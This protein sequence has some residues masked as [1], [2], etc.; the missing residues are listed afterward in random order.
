[1]RKFCIFL[2]ISFF[3]ISC[4]YGEKITSDSF[5]DVDG[6]L[7]YEKPETGPVVYAVFLLVTKKGANLDLQNLDAN[8]FGNGIKF[9]VSNGLMKDKLYAEKHR[10]LL[11]KG[12]IDRPIY[13]LSNA[14]IYFH[15][16]ES[17]FSKDNVIEQNIQTDT[18]FYLGKDIKFNYRFSWITIDSIRVNTQ[19]A[20]KD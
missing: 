1:M 17:T 15:I 10:K 16:D 13:L 19:P 9:N 8:D 12:G 3:V 11:L 7:Y 2:G 4:T 14:K 18:L 5:K 20:N 6:L